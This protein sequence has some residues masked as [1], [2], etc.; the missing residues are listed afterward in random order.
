MAVDVLE[1]R[2]STVSVAREVL[3]TVC[4]AGDLFCV[5]LGFGDGVI[6][7]VGDST[8]AGWAVVVV[9]T[10]NGYPL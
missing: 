2:T 4:V 6:P 8:G 9:S 3:V 7:R 10:G 5:A 1:G